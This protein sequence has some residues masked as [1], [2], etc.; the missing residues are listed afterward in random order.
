VPVNVSP[1]ESKYVAQGVVTLKCCAGRH[2][3]VLI[4]P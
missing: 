3:G 4:S 1:G 2:T